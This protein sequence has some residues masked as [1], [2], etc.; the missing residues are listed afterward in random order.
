M[1]ERTR[2]D[3]AR[4]Y[5]PLTGALVAVLLA[6]FVLPS[7][8]NV[9]QSNPTQTLEFAPVPP[10]DDAPPQP[11]ASGNVSELALGSSAGPEGDEPGGD[12]QGLPPPP[13]VPEGVGDVPVSKRCVGGPP[14]QTSDPMAPPCVAHFEGD[15]GGATYP[16]VSADEIT[17][18]FYLDPVGMDSDRGYELEENYTGQYVDIAAPAQADDTVRVR[19]LR[20]LSRHFND[21]YQTYDRF[22]HF[23]AYFSASPYDGP[24]PESRRAEAA[25]NV[26]DRRPFAVITTG[27]LAGYELEYTREVARQGAL[28]FGSQ[29][30]VQPAEL[31]ATYPGR[32]WSYLPTIEKLAGLYATYVCTKVVDEPVV[33]SGNQEY[34]GQPRK[35]GFL[36]S[37]DATH[38]HLLAFADLVR[39]QVEGCGGRFEET[40]TFPR[41]DARYQVGQED[42]AALYA[43]QNVARFQQADVT[44][45]VWAGGFETDQSRAA[46]RVEY[47][48]EW[49]VAGDGY[50]EGHS[51]AGHQGQDAWQHAWVVSTVVYEPQGDAG[52]TPCERALREADPNTGGRDA[53][54]ACSPGWFR[55]TRQLFTGIQVAGPRLTPD[56]MDQGFHAIP[57]VASDDPQVPAC[58]YEPG[59]YTCV[60]DAAAMHWDSND[61][62]AGYENGGCWRIVEGGARYLAGDWPPG[63][64]DAQWQPDD[65]PC[66]DFNNLAYEF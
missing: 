3:L 12:G 54:R 15:N 65:A 18:L 34:Q 42:S 49:I 62:A 5:P 46:E 37:S 27:A 11:E 23:W 21:R 59:D 41:A 45:I 36:S 44:T 24:T 30:G 1:A 57:Q 66:N 60:K 39:E 63:N 35:L 52:E 51:N 40:A 25:K 50:Q 28:V 8:L 26:V 48:P 53:N 4:T 20:R 19:N 7:A 13:P 22:V 32:I 10:A 58:F 38:P 2:R 61:S 9:P 56:T 31:F 55:D 29:S 64:I 6:V 47:Y 43:T 14:R 17:V 33:D 16:G